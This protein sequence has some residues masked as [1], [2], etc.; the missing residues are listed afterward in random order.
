MIV[1]GLTGSI[2]M[3]KSA[4]AEMFAA[5]G[6]PVFDADAEVHRQYQAGGKAAAAIAARWPEVM[7]RGA[8]ERTRLSAKIMAEPET[9]AAVEMIVHPLVRAA[10]QEFLEHC[11]ERH[12]PVALLDIPLLFE[13]GR[14]REVDKIVVVSAT[15]SIQR[16][17]VLSRPD[18]AEAKFERILHRQL[19]DTEKRKRADFVVDTSQGFDYARSQV[20]A[21]L[22]SLK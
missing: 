4:T 3:G 16:Q 11:R 5:E 14:E 12:C 9:L 8:V 18:M 7:D 21:I 6:V 10:Q 2:A 22:A 20:R 13:T 19:P 17:R 1:L 15:E